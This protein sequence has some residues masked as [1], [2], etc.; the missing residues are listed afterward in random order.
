MHS[1]VGAARGLALSTRFYSAA[2]G[3]VG[4]SCHRHHRQVEQFLL[5]PKPCGPSS[6]CS[7]LQATS[8]KARFAPFQLCTPS[9]A[10]L[11]FQKQVPTR[12]FQRWLLAWI[13]GWVLGLLS[14]CCDASLSKSGHE[15]CL[16]ASD[17]TRGAFAVLAVFS[18]S[19][20]SDFSKSKIVAP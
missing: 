18:E 6:I 17:A 7:L 16:N 5:H 12:H 15:A 3:A 13:K 11:T 2:V 4:K 9:V 8:F 19:Q 1:W 10:E 14:K 20:Q